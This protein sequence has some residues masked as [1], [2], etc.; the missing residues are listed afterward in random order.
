ML[1]EKIRR[2]RLAYECAPTTEEHLRTLTN[3]AAAHQ[4]ENRRSPRLKW[5]QSPWEI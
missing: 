4:T 5:Q 2:T 3:A 1:S